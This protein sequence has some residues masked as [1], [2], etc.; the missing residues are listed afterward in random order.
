MKTLDVYN[1]AI[2]WAVNGDY[3]DDDV[4]EAKLSFFQQ[5]STWINLCLR[6]KFC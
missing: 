1:R 6:K 5:V 4:C 2:D 3:N